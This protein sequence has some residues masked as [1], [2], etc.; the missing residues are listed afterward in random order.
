MATSIRDAL[1]PADVVELYSRLWIPQVHYIG[2]GSITLITYEHLITA[3]QEYQV[4][5]RRKSSTCS[6][7][8]NGGTTICCKVL[9]RM[10][11]VLSVVLD[12]VILVFLSVRIHAINDRRW[13]WTLAV[14]LLG[15]V[16]TPPTL[17]G[18][19][20]DNIATSIPEVAMGCYPALGALGPDP[21]SWY[22]LLLAVRVCVIV[23]NV[24]VLGIT[25]YRTIGIVAAARSA[26]I[27]ASVGSVLL[28]DGTMYFLDKRRRN[29]DTHGRIHLS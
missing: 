4:I 5:W 8:S 24:I 12:L 15:F 25:W 22:K 11:G 13:G 1:S 28:R 10:L 21:D 2:L 26:N 27:K 23:Q 20:T 3:H 9:S 29:R 18:V 7:I 14:F 6:P 17:V 16:A 19:A